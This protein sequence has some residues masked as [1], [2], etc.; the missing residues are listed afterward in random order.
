MIRIKILFL[1]V[2][3][4]FICTAINVFAQGVGQT[5]SSNV[6]L[7][8][9][10]DYS[11][12]GGA[13][14]WGWKNGSNHFALVTLDA[15]LSIINTTNTSS[16]SEVVH[17]NR[18]SGDLHA[19]DVET[20]SSGGNT[21]AYLA[22]HSTTEDY[23]VLIINLNEAINESGSYTINPDGSLDDVFVGRIEN[24]EVGSWE[25][26]T[27]TIAGNFLY[28]ATQKDKIPIYDLS[29][30]PDDPDYIGAITTPTDNIDSWGVHEMFVKSTG[31]N[32][33]IIY[34][35][36]KRDGLQKIVV[37]NISSLTNSITEHLYDSDK[38]YASDFNSGDSD[39][40]YRLTHSAWPT[41][42]GD[43]IFTTDE[44]KVWPTHSSTV[45]LSTDANLYVSG[46]LNDVHRQAIFYAHGK[47]H[48]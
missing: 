35:A 18:S 30:D 26:H 8:C 11:R 4:L 32:S 2:L 31:S 6:N 15:G 41:D 16:P 22:V 42:D 36:C 9:A 27:L 48:N 24:E 45:N 47:P 40:D 29:S 33:S 5:W 19:V 23:Y 25:A 28:V 21:Y 1:C 44:I 37:S 43:Y 3:V 39:F 38:A 10:T 20:Y 7:K 34:A 12:G 13:D 46:T 14:V 17:I